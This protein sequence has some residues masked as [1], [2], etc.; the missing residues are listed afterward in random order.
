MTW[1]CSISWFQDTTPAIRSLLHLFRRPGSTQTS[2]TRRKLYAASELGQHLVWDLSHFHRTYCEL[3]RDISKQ[4]EVVW[5]GGKPV[6]R[7]PPPAHPC[8]TP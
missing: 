2:V 5:E 3:L 6:P 1:K 4:V 8:F 7:K